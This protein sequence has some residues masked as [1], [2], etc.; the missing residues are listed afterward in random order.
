MMYYIIELFNIDTFI[1]LCK[2]VHLEVAKF[3][4]LVKPDINIDN[5]YTF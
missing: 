1:E 4:F 3:L 5:E 2:N